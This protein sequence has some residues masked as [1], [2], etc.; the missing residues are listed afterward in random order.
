MLSDVS[1]AQ[2]DECCTVLSWCRTWGG[3]SP[4]DRKQNGGAGLGVG[5]TRALRAQ[6]AQSLSL[7]R[8]EVLERHSG[9]RRQD[10]MTLAAL[11][12]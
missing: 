8:G 1:L 12:T 4:G 10:T 5:G 6:W 3:R 2:R 7:S 9:D 11:S